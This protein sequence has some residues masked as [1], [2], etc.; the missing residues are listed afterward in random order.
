[1][2]EGFRLGGEKLKA[3]AEQYGF[4]SGF[5][6]GI[7]A[8]VGKYPLPESD[9]ELAAS[10]IGQGRVSVSPL[11]MASVAAA[12]RTGAWHAP[13]LVEPTP[14]LARRLEE[15]VATDLTAMMRAVV[16]DEDGTATNVAVD[17]VEIGGKT[18]TA[19]FGDE[20]PPETHAWFIGYVGDLAFAIV[21]E[22]GGV[23][24]P[25]AGPIARAF[26]ESLPPEFLTAAG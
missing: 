9:S 5:D 10:A 22:G 8:V 24:G 7:P 26:I 18:G 19:E 2:D 21:V 6:P 4:N 20:E 12:A 15:G 13:Y 23:G 14:D 16:E 3:Q 17:G 11:H 25:V 1:M